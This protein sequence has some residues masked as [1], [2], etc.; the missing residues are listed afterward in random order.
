VACAA[1]AVLASSCGGT[2]VSGPLG[3]APVP[4]QRPEPRVPKPAA[5]PVRETLVSVTVLDGDTNE[6]VTGAKVAIQGAE[7]RSRTLFA[8]RKRALVSATVSAPHYSSRTLR[9][10]LDRFRHVTVR[11]YRPDGQWTMY[12]A[13]PA[14]SQVHPNIQ[15]RPPF[16]VVWGR[17][18]GSLLEF[19]A[20]V[21][22]GRAY[23]SN[24]H[25]KL[26]ALSMDTGKTLWS[27]DMHAVEQD[28][29]PA[30]VGENVVAHSKGGHVF[31]LDRKT[32]R[33]RWSWA[34]AGGIESSPVVLD[35]IDYFG[36]WAGNVYALDLRRHRLRWTHHDGC[37]I[38]A[39]A[40]VVGG[41]VYIGDYCGR[42]LALTASTGTLRFSA[43]AGSPVY[44]TSA[45]ANGRVFVPS[46]DAG[47]LYAFTTSG[48]YL[49]HVR[50]GAYVYSAPAV[51]QGRVFFGSYNGVLYCVSAA[52]GSVLWAVGTG[53][54][55]SGSPTVI[56]GIVYAGNF[57]H[58]IV[59]VDAHT[60]RIRFRFPHGE[61]VAVSGNRGRL[62]MYGWSSLWAVEPKQ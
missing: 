47:A 22:E 30:V 6:P 1:V 7:R 27:F 12:G 39:S 38:T 40:A 32:G 33:L 31:V 4:Q 61:Y 3:H 62:L 56:D 58:Q 19:P 17:N 60:G 2:R 42:L 59:G 44:G 55:I 23:L 25:G 8:L 50:T 48:S 35:G 26:F 14:R 28:S 53:G 36:D 13:D 52:S 46:R 18:L 20:V 24:L 37:K 29:S 11:L 34:S 15:L 5:P 9:L 57:A 10:P 51:W 45:V 21:E 49:W 16:R 54:A 41:T 43:S